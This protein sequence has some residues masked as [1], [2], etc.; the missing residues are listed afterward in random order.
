MQTPLCGSVVTIQSQFINTSFH[1]HRKEDSQQRLKITA[2]W[3][4]ETENK[5]KWTSRDLALLGHFSPNFQ[6]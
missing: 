3:R 6:P 4:L 5:N 1:H 2:V